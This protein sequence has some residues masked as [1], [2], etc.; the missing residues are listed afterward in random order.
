[1]LLQN[2]QF[3]DS[4]R[5]TRSRTEIMN[6]KQQYVLLAQRLLNGVTASNFGGKFACMFIFRSFWK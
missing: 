3:L 2:A 5:L 6:S 1:M 4:Y